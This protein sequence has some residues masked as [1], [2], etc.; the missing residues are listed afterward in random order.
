ML[1]ALGE[2]EKMPEVRR[3]GKQCLDRHEEHEKHEMS[4]VR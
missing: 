4:S 3:G 1:I 2:H